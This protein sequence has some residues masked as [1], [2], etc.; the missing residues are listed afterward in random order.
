ME[1]W[2]VVRYT[3]RLRRS[4]I[5]FWDEWGWFAVVFEKCQ[6]TRFILICFAYLVLWVQRRYNAGCLFSSDA[7]KEQKTTDTTYYSDRLKPNEKNGNENRMVNLADIA[8]AIFRC[9]SGTVELAGVLVFTFEIANWKC[10]LLY[11]VKNAQKNWVEQ[12]RYLEMAPDMRFGNF[13]FR[14]ISIWI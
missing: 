7:G 6:L 13:L 5:R 11:R 2:S 9:M 12:K 14:S 10:A 8:L 1:W 4:H 3:T